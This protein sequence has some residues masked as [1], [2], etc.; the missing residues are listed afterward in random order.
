MIILRFLIFQFPEFFWISKCY[1]YFCTWSYVSWI[2]WLYIYILE[3][4]TIWLVSFLNKYII[5]HLFA[6]IYFFFF[7]FHFWYTSLD[8]LIFSCRFLFV[9]FLVVWLHMWDLS[10]LTRDWTHAPALEAQHLNHWTTREVPV[11]SPTREVL[12]WW[13]SSIPYF[14]VTLSAST[15]KSITIPLPLWSNREA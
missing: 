14:S 11:G 7:C 3:T 10:S 6:F 4:F 13:T 1:L 15:L 9:Y 12:F 5:W 8:H 2:Q